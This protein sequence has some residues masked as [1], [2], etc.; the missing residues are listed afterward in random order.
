MFVFKKKYFFI[1]ESIKDI[2]LSKLK[3][4][5]KFNIIYRFDNLTEKVEDLLIYR[6]LCKIKR[7]G[8]YI[9]NSTAL[10]STLKADGLYVSAF[11]KSLKVVQLK[12]TIYKIIG[13][14]HNLK[15]FNVKRIQGCSTIFFSR[16]FKTHY[17][18]KT[19]YHGLIKFN[20]IN[21]NYR[22]VLFPLGG[23]N[24]ENFN[25][26]RYI[27]TDSIALSSQIKI[28]NLFNLKLY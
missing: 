16:L 9:S 28:D 7:I 17:K 27:K 13:S 1:I 2:D 15:E 20:L 18:N 12:N 21:H 25:K 14:A 8:F 22:N 23:L 11:N 6:N 4:S 5:N 26:I 24:N 19:N 10:M 3:R